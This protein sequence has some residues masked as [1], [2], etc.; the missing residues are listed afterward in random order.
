MIFAD[1]K[2]ETESGKQY[3]VYLFEGE[4]SFFFGRGVSYLKSKFLT[5]ENLNFA[6]FSG[7]DV[8]GV[9]ASFSSLPFMSEKRITLV[10]EFYPDAK[11]IS[12]L[13]GFL[14]NPPTDGMLIV[15]NAKKSEALKKFKSVA[16][17][18]CDKLKPYE[19]AKWIKAKCAE[20]G[21][22]IGSAAELIAEYCL[23]DMLRIE[24]ETEKLIAMCDGGEITEDVV[25]DSVY[26][27]SDYEIFRM[28]DFIAK[29]QFTQAVTVVSEMLKKE[30]APNKLILSIYKY[31]RRLLHARISDLSDDELSRAYGVKPTAVPRIKE[32]AKKFSSKALKK[33]VDELA[34]A[35]YQI[36]SGLASADEKL[37]ITVFGIMAEG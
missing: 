37:W 2:R 32:Q 25:K 21:V 10:K 20:S 36:K 16:V 27:D 29:R 18:E 3:A 35:D 31:F 4:E 5:E 9:I 6:S 26:R 30:N 12:E 14:E 34:D 24:N 23:C 11:V 13:K 7:D 15:L 8:E 1:F 22:K 17:I 28:T 19:A 33:A